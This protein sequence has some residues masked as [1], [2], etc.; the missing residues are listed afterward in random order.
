MPGRGAVKKSKEE[1]EGR[2][3]DTENGR[4]PNNSFMR[5]RGA[6]FIDKDRDREPHKESRRVIEEKTKPPVKDSV[7]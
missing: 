3:Y 2:E 6:E 7:R 4:N 5:A 1:V